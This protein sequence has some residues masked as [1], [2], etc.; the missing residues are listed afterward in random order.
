MGVEQ[1]ECVGDVGDVYFHSDARSPLP[2]AGGGR[3]TYQ[4]GAGEFVDS[5]AE[6]NVTFVAKSFGRR[7]DLW[8][9]SYRCAHVV[10][11][12]SQM[13]GY[14]TG[15]AAAGAL[16][17]GRLFRGGFEDVGREGLGGGLLGWV[18]LVRRVVARVSECVFR[19]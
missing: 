16:G 9:K 19:V 14:R 13:Q 11:V 7:R 8:I 5:F 15:D 6:P 17:P 2:E 3:F 1:F 4:T 12:A 18:L 10:S